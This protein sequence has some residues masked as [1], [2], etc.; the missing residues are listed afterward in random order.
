MLKKVVLAGLLVVSGANAGMFDSVVSAVGGGSTAK[1]VDGN[2]LDSTIQNYVTAKALLQ[3]SSEA[4][5]KAILSKEESGKF[6]SALK[7]AE[8][9]S[10]PKEKDAAISK[11]VSDVQTALKAATESKQTVEQI[12]KADKKTREQ[13]AVGGFNFMLSG[14]KYKDTLA[15]AKDMVSSLSSNPTAAM[16]YASQL[17]QLKDMVTTLPE[18]VTSIATIGSKLV[19]LYKA[20][21][22]NF[23]APTSSSQAP[24]ESSK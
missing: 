10:D 20:G 17:E 7:A 13:L 4:L 8:S 5:S 11:A 14:L 24:K 21:K 3:K 1:A 18:S 23:T 19:D 12:K 2:A 16:Q 15:S 9:I 6:E 22:V